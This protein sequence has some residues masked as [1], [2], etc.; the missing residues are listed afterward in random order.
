MTLRTAQE[1]LLALDLDRLPPPV[2]AAM[3]NQPM[4][5][6]PVHASGSGFD[7]DSWAALPA[8]A[9]RD[10][11]CKLGIKSWRDGGSLRPIARGLPLRPAVAKLLA[12]PTPAQRKVAKAWLETD[13]PL[14]AHLFAYV[15]F[16]D[17]S[18]T[19]WLAG[20]REIRFLSACQRGRSAGALAGAMPRIRQ[21][22]QQVSRGLAPRIHVIEVACLADGDVRLIEVN[23]GL[24][25]AEIE[26][27]LAA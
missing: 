3:F 21:L 7:A 27:L 15:D 2:R 12:E 16:A 10:L 20:P 5:S 23:P 25:P 13:T 14:A 4:F 17:I 19:R 24:Q 11:F 18:E 8:D 6:I 26:A 22:V 9:P 1:K